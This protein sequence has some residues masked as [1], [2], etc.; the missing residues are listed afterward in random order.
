LLFVGLTG[1][2]G[3]GKS[4]ALAACERLGAATLSSDAVVH[5]LLGTE[6]VRELVRER[7]GEQVVA[8]DEVDR[9]AVAAIVFERPEELAWLEG[10]LFPRVGMRTAAWRME[11]EQREPPP[12]IAVVEVPLLFEAGREGFFDATIAVVADEALREERAAAR[13]HEGV[14]GREE[15]QLSQEEKAARAD[16]VIRN[17]GSLAELE[18]TVGAVLDQLKASVSG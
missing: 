16:F 15:R 18:G 11:L 10:E 17:D 12:D 13:G 8:G 5:E 3:S 7:W 2:L 4:E 6:E 9:A 14:A 1:G